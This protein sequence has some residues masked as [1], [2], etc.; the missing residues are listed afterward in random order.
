MRHIF[1]TLKFTKKYQVS[2]YGEVRNSKTKK[3]LKPYKIPNGR[4]YVSLSLKNKRA[5]QLAKHVLQH[6]YKKEL[7]KKFAL[8]LDCNLENCKSPN[9]QPGTRGDV[10]RMFFTIRNKKRGVYKYSYTYPNGKVW[11]RYKVQFKVKNKSKI[12]GYYKTKKQAQHVYI[13]KYIQTYGYS[14]FSRN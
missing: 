7:G 5:R 12:F 1:K 11:S 3:I 13:N 2:N 8:H 14:P 4:L 6:F 10:K 9:L